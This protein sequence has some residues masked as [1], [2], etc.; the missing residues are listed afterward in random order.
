MEF[1]PEFVPNLTKLDLGL[2]GLLNFNDRFHFKRASIDTKR[3]RA[4]IKVF[5]LGRNLRIFG[6]KI[7]WGVFMTMENV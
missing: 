2:G 6:R 1:L 5:V 4:R 3:S 7:I